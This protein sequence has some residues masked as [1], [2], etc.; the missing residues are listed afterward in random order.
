MIANKLYW[1][2]NETACRRNIDKLY[3]IRS[4]L[5]LTE[6]VEM[7]RDFEGNKLHNIDQTS[8]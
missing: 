6:L 4:R 5:G 7:D 3:N 8:L 2:L 1:W